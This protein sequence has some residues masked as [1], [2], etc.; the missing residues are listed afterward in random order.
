M[1]APCRKV[2]RYIAA[3][4]FINNRLIDS[5]IGRQMERESEREWERLRDRVREKEKD[6]CREIKRDEERT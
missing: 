3:F 4:F 1:V 2:L 6:R 5:N